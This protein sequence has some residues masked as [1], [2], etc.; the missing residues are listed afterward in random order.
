MQAKRTKETIT[1]QS[2]EFLLRQASRARA[3]FPTFDKWY[4]KTHKKV[5]PITVT[6]MPADEEAEIQAEAEKVSEESKVHDL[7]RH[8]SNTRPTK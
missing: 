5:N 2:T 7:V 1:V 4:R 6:G 3:D 8:L